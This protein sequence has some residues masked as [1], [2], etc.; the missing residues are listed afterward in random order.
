MK[1]NIKEAIFNQ[2]DKLCKT[3]I[4]KLN[5]RNKLFLYKL[6]KINTDRDFY[7]SHSNFE[8]RKLVTKFR[9][10]DHSLELEVGRYKKLPRNMRICNFCSRNELD[11]EFHF[12]FHC[13][14]TK[15]PLK[16]KMRIPIS[17]I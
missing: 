17:R 2:Y 8:F 12:F 9:I 1:N 10:C 16:L 7:L 14:K 4:E 3:S 15:Y 6:L 5:E 13:E 11:D